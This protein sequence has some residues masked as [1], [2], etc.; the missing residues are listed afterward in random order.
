MTGMVNG[1]NMRNKHMYTTANVDTRDGSEG[2]EDEQDV[3]ELDDIDNDNNDDGNRL[4]EGIMKFNVASIVKDL[5][6][7]MTPRTP[8]HLL[9]DSDDES[10]DDSFIMSCG[11][12]GLLYAPGKKVTIGN[13]FV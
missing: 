2:D 11:S 10:D 8:N 9:I 12:D 5:D 4:F 6:L 13:C 3:D 1:T 7:P